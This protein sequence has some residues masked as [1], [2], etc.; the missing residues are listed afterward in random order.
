MTASTGWSMGGKATFDK[1]R[2]LDASHES[3]NLAAF[4]RLGDL[5]ELQLKQTPLPPSRLNI[6]TERAVAADSPDHTEP[7]GTKNDNTRHPRFVRRCEQLLPEIRHLDVG[8]AGGGLVWDFTLAGHLS[9]GVEGSDFNLRE[10]RAEWRILPDRLFT[11]DVCAPF[12][13]RRDDGGPV[14]FNLVTA[15]ELFEH[16]PTASVDSVISNL[17]SNMS[18]DA[19]LVCSIA[20]FVDRDEETGTVY[21]QTVKPKEWWLAQFEAHGL[22]ERDRLFD[23]ADFVRGNGNPRAPDWDIRINPEMGFHLT[24]VRGDRD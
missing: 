21:H 23:I 24:L 17:V 5:L 18:E 15:W 2:L 13:I 14:L 7:R 8:C 16:I 3:A 6:A 19:I 9:V 12:Q 22:R 4:D 10:R 20:T 1:L 11:A